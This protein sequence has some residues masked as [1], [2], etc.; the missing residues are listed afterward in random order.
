MPRTIA[1]PLA[2]V[3][4]KLVVVL[5]TPFPSITLAFVKSVIASLLR[6]KYKVASEPVELYFLQPLLEIDVLVVNFLCVKS[7]TLL[8]P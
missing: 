6:K 8:L 7:L 5:T 2:S 1:C 4:Q 3:V